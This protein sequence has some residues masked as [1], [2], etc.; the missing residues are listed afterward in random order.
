M[1]SCL[2]RVD[3]V[4]ECGLQA[5]TSNQESINIRLL[6]QLCAVLLRYTASVQDAGLLRG[7]R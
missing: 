4:E 1:H 5:R 2:V 3:D 6:G 7:L